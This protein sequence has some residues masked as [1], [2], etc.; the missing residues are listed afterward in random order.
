MAGAGQL[1]DRALGVGALGDILEKGRLDLV[2]QRLLHRLAAEVV[3]VAP[4]EVADRPDIDEADLQLI[5]RV[6]VECYGGD[7]Q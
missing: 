2:A 3:L 7:R 4:A 1:L 5:R 6:S